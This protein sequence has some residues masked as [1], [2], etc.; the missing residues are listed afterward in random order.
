MFLDSCSPV[1]ERGLTCCFCRSSWDFFIL[2]DLESNYTQLNLG[3]YGTKISYLAWWWEQYEDI[4]D[5]F[6]APYYIFFS[7][8]LFKQTFSF[9][10]FY[11]K[12]N[13]W[14]DLS[15]QLVLQTWRGSVTIILEALLRRTRKKIVG[16]W[17]IKVWYNE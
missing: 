16:F 11:E 13:N 8:W 9:G 12:I 14:S 15:L 5:V 10:F 6:V 3:I 17:S 1:P 2:L 4:I 7:P